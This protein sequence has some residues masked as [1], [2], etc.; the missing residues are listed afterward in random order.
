[1]KI[2]PTDMTDT[3][4]NMHVRRIAGEPHAGKAILHDVERFHHYRGEARPAVARDD[5]PLERAFGREH[6][7]QPREAVAGMF[8]RLGWWSVGQGGA[9]ARDRGATAEPVG[10]HVDGDDD[11]GAER[12]CG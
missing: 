4:R 10:I 9:V 12:P 8:S 1:M 5:L 11:P 2:E 7:A 3:R 6:A